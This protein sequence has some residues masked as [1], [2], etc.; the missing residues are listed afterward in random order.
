[1]M[2]MR[3]PPAALLAALALAGCVAEGQPPAPVAAVASLAVASRCGEVVCRENLA[4]VVGKE[5][6]L[7]L[8]QPDWRLD[9]T[10]V[11]ALIVAAPGLDAA[12]LRPDPQR[13]AAA[14][15][16]DGAERDAALAPLADA[17]RRYTLFVVPVEDAEHLAGLN[18]RRDGF[19]LHTF[20]GRTPFVHAACE[21]LLFDA[22]AA[23]V[24]RSQRAVARRDV[25]TALGQSA[26][27]N[28]D[29]KRLKLIRAELEKVADAAGRQL[30]GVLAA[31]A[32]P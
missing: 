2:P 27:W 24:V 28:Y 26:D 32:T 17:G 19:G 13:F 12:T 8:R 14:A 15:A 3:P 18:S 6:R 25:P 21:G 10:L 7:P 9:D 5:A 11:A 30:P 16:L 22:A 29:D 1:M 23:T 31:P 4:P 20:R